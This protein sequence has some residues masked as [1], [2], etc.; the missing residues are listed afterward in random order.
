MPPLDQIR[1]RVV[2]DYK[3]S[4]ALQQARTA[5]QQSARML[6]NSI[7]QGKSLDQAFHR[8]L[9][10]RPLAAL[11]LSTRTLPEVEDHLTL[12]QL[13]QMAFTTPGGKVSDFQPTRDGGLFW[14]S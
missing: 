12:N 3:H 8:R 7:A 14:R 10:A 5:G 9:K 13:K 6:T 1:D 4:Q 2:A 11:S